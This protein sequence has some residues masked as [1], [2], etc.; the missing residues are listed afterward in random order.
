MYFA[1]AMSNK[2]TG[3]QIVSRRI[4]KQNQ[5]EQEVLRK[6]YILDSYKDAMLEE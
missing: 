1:G 2:N 5:I 4:T 6:A 3:L